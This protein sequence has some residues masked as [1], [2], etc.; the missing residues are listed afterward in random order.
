MAAAWHGPVER[1]QIQLC[2][3][4]ISAMMSCNRSRL[5]EHAAELEHGAFGS[6]G[7]ADPCASNRLGRHTRENRASASFVWSRTTNGCA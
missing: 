7:H 4:L 5:A 3:R 2:S 1:A 6:C